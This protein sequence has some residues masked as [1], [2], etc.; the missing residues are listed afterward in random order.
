[1]RT[2]KKARGLDGDAVL[3]AELENPKFRYYFEQR[4]LVHEVAIAVR[5]M[6]TAAGLT[7]AQLAKKIGTSQPAIA[8]LET[9]LD[10]RTPR[11]DTL[12]RIATALGRKLKFK[13]AASSGDAHF[14]EVES[15]VRRR[16]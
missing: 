8:R 15:P 16:P 1:M 12:Q 2:A 13:F 10:V 7:Q 3:A 11:W 5:G 4:R 9:G 14:V 6:R